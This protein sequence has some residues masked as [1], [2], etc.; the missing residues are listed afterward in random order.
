MA[1]DVVVDPLPYEFDAS[2]AGGG[3]HP[4]HFPD[5]AVSDV[6]LLPGFIDGLGIDADLDF[7]G[8]LDF[9]I[10]DLLDI[11][12][13]ED[14]P[15]P[16][17]AVSDCKEGGGLS[18]SSSASVAAAG[19]GF[20]ELDG[21]SNL[22]SPES[23]DSTTGEGLV[24]L[25][26]EEERK[27]WSLKRKKGRENGEV[28]EISS[29]PNARSSKCRRS[30]PSEKGASSCVFNPGCEEED[31]RKARLMRNRESAQLSRQ[32]KKHYVEELEEKVRA[33][34]STITEL[35]SKISF[36][37]AENAT[38]RQQ[39]TSGGG[40]VNC[41]LPAVYPPPVTSMHF[42]WIPCS[43]YTLRPPGSQVPLIPIPRLKTQQVASAPKPK[44]SESRK[45]EGKT[46]KVAGVSLLGLLFCM[47]FVGVFVPGSKL[48][49]DG[50]GDIVF[51]ERSFSNG[52]L[53]GHSQDR[54]LTVRGDFDRSNVTEEVGNRSGRMGVGRGDYG[55]RLPRSE[56]QHEEHRSQNVPSF[57]GN[58]TKPLFAS[59]YVP[60]NDKLV[61]ID[62][63]LIIHSVLAS[64][65][66]KAHLAS[67]AKSENATPHSGKDNK[68][69]SLAIAG[70]LASALAISQSGRDV[71]RRARLYRSIAEHQRALAYGSKD[72]YRDNSK[73][74]PA[75]G[76]VKE[77]FREGLEG[78]ILSSGMCTEVFQFDVSANSGGIVPAPPLTNVTVKNGNN[79][80]HP[81]R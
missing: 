4:L 55:S 69:T 3:F 44:K 47:L 40:S 73:S 52:K 19:E 5:D 21:S 20:L 7:D 53:T 79:S 56:V 45:A 24:K 75:D 58:D 72:K 57:T 54:V 18:S 43:G 13:A 64:E 62:G 16:A 29:N 30:G 8:D 50:R 77:W 66:A 9:S 28:T 35:N 17:A 48:S 68:E 81:G 6:P 70:N 27:G 15:P 22:S 11:P 32:R 26:E 61:K 23:D 12:D 65:K 42:P 60:R 37:M 39:L 31:K 41:P 63:N 67:G 14:D 74:T 71:E 2:F 46:K 51:S 1:E 10:A 25:E 59:L 38:L 33:M 78:P 36:I 80:S 34:H 76:P 49:L